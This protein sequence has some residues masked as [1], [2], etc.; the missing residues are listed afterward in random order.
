MHSATGTTTNAKIFL[1]DVLAQKR[2]LVTGG[3]GGL[4][5]EIATGLARHGA[6]VHICGRRLEM[7]KTTADEIATATGAK[8]H[9]HA[10]DVRDADAVDALVEDIWTHGPLTG[11][12]NN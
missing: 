8:V 1:P 11:L 4:G 3:G 6:A 5:K 12:V 10:C 7:L 2:V 9:A